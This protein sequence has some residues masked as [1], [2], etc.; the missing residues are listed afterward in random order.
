MALNEQ[1][2]PVNLGKGL[3]WNGLSKKQDG[4]AFID[5]ARTMLIDS[6]KC[7]SDQYKS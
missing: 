5:L 7:C 6:A 3:G 1:S 4:I 2:L